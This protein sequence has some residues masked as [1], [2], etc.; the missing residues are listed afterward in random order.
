MVVYRQ[1]PYGHPLRTDPA[2]L[3]GRYHPGREASPTQYLCLH[4]LAP[5]AEFVR[6][7]SLRL[8]DQARQVRERTWALRLEQDGLLGV[9]FEN[10]RDYGLDAR[11]L[12]DDDLSRCQAFASEIRDAGVP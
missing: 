7:N 11:D 2:R 10:A 1:A 8:P 12:V 3:A 9:G 5:F 4:P 6:G